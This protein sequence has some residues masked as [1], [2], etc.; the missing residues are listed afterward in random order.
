[1]RSRIIVL[2]LVVSAIAGTLM[3]VDSQMSS[4]I[5]LPKGEEIYYVDKGAGASAVLSDLKNKGIIRISLPL[6]K[7]YARLTESEGPL[8]AGEYE[9]TC[10]MNHRDMLGLLRSGRVKQYAITFPEGIRCKDWLDV[11]QVEFKGEDAGLMPGC[12]TLMKSLDS[13]MVAAEGQFYPDTYHY[14]RGDNYLDILQR[15]HDRMLKVLEEAWNNRQPDLPLSSQYE[16]LILASIV[17]KETGAE[18]DRSLVASVF[19]NRLNKG[20]RLQSDPTIIYGLNDYEGNIKRRHITQETPYNTY[21]I[22]G[23]PPTPISN[24][25]RASIVAVLNPPDTDY[26]Y[27]VAKGNGR[28]YFSTTLEEHNKAVREFQ[29][30]NRSDKYRSSPEP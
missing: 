10:D 24:P 19:I 6:M 21:V 15:A 8:K 30:N 22:S 20:M 25:G 2:C 12:D 16:A 7:I 26:L 11:L 9:L 13:T 1:M 3:F 14:V 17:E 23:L 27:F 28:S 4:R 5:N 18:E 29:I